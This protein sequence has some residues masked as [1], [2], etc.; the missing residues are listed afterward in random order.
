[1]D[2]A[3]GTG[4]VT[5]PLLKNGFKVVSLDAN[6][7][8][9]KELRLK[10]KKLGVKNCQTTILDMRKLDYREKFD[11]VCVRQAINYFIGI[12]SLETSLEKIFASLKTSGK[13][14]FNAPNY[15]GKRVYPTVTNYYENDAQKAFVVETNEMWGKLLKHKQYSIIWDDKKKPYFVTDENSFYMFTKRE[16]ERALRKCGFSKIEFN[17]PNKTLYCVAIK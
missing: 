2:L 10:A 9:L 14:I 12:K 15:H 13:F 3:A 17:K 16:F 1:M 8:M 5:I 11:S 7:G 4:E 6:K